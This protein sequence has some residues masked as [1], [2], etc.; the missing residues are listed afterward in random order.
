LN[1]LF[2][3][4]SGT[5]LFEPSVDVPI[6]D[7]GTR[8]AQ[9]DVAKISEKIEVATYEKSIQTAFREVADGLAAQDGYHDQLQAQQALVDATRSYYQQAQNRYEKGVDSYLTLLDAQRSLFSA[10]QGLVS[11]RLALLSNRVSLFK[12]LG[13]GWSKS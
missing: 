8:E 10:E 2:D 12:A 4:G 5:W 9:L 13:G 7:W 6:F 11:T 1:K 3:G